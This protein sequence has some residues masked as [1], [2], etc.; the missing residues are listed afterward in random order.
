MASFRGHITLSTPLGVCYGALGMLRPE[1][2]WGTM[3]VGGSFTA[4]AGML[5]D[6]DSQS[7]KPARELFALL[8][9]IV[10]F[11]VFHPMREYGFSLDQAAAGMILAY[12][13]VRYVVAAMFNKMTAHRGMFHSIPTMLI[14]GLLTYLCYPSRDVAVRLYLAGG[15]MFGFLSH[16][17]LDEIWAIDFNGMAFQANQFSGTAFKFFSPSLSANVITY[18]MLFALGYAVWEGVP[19]W[20]RDPGNWQSPTWLS[21]ATQQL[22]PSSQPAKPSNSNPQEPANRPGWVTDGRPQP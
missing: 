2:D 15:I 7:G 17:I 4:V 3:V 19:T 18:A 1:F 11:G 13:F 9:A 20:V 12:F 14:F 21:Q 6:L 8:P 22:K 10:G 16:L 5:P